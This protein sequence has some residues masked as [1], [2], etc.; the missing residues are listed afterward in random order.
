MTLSLLPGAGDFLVVREGM[1][2]EEWLAERE[3]GVG[4][5]DA[6]AIVGVSRW[7]TPLSVWQNKTN[8]G[9][10]FDEDNP[11]MEAGRYLEPVIVKWFRDKTELRAE[12]VGTDDG[13][14]AIVYRK[15]RPH[16]RCTPDAL[17]WLDKHDAKRL[18][19]PQYDW[20]NGVS[21][22][23]RHYEGIGLLEVKTGAAWKADEWRDGVPIEY[24]VQVQEQLMVTGCAFAFIAVLLGGN[25]F[26]WYFVERNESFITALRERCGRFW[27]DY[28]ENDVP[29]PVI[30]AGD[31]AL[32]QGMNAG[33]EDGTSVGLDGIFMEYDEEIVKL[34]DTEREAAARIK[35]LKAKIVQGIGSATTG[36]LPNGVKWTNKTQERKGY[37][38]NVAPSKGKVLRRGK[39]PDKRDW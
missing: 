29:P 37:T 12:R 28:V 18:D 36:V 15:D 24:D 35:L 14:C 7:G 17:V 23:K 19:L 6:A 9:E 26:R 21:S 27:A 39:A 16:E 4:S 34:Q 33:M 32:L 1:T 25:D 20:D 2:R 38:R 10:K 13:D 22:G 11:F 3:K 31:F 8:R 30:A 5:S